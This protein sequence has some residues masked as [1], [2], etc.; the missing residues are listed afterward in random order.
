MTSK[1]PRGLLISPYHAR[2]HAIWAREFELLVDIIDWRQISLPPRFFS[3]RVRGNP[4]A[5]VYEP[6]FSNAFNEIDLLVVTSMT[7]L[8]TL[9]GLCR[10]LHRVPC[11]YY[12][13]ENQFAYP[14]NVAT[15]STGNLE[16][17]MVSLY[18]AL[19][20]D[21]VVFNSLFNRDT[22]LRGASEMLAKFPDHSPQNCIDAIVPKCSVIPVALP[23]EL[24][25]YSSEQMSQGLRQPTER[26]LKVAWNHRWEY[27][28]RPEQLVQIIKLAKQQDLNCQFFIFGQSFRE[29]P[30]DFVQ[31]QERFPKYVAH[32]GHLAE[33][34]AYYRALSACDIVL[35]TAAHDFQGL[36]ILEGMRC[37]CVPVVP[38]RLAY[39]E[40]VPEDY[41]YQSN[42]QDQATEARAV[43]A[44]LTQRLLELRSGALGN[45]P[46]V[47]QTDRSALKLRYEELCRRL[48]VD[49]H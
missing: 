14:E 9:R 25:K 28:K 7:D 24:E 44:M 32:M 45:P 29:I 26:A 5:L 2:S 20:A 27:D 34:E 19:C 48:L 30:E 39:R 3:W 6:E 18:G 1:Q 15:K 12:F 37:G 36:S 10:D 21:H 49:S 4:L 31:L 11:V 47:P 38:D 43:V 33:S 13:H 42:L 46:A 22:F 16:A 35:S 17:K 41:R 40:Y 8:A 23:H